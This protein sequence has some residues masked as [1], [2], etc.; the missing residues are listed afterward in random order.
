MKQITFTE[1]E[2][3]KL[4]IIKEIVEWKLSQSDWASEL[5]ISTRQMR[6]LQRWYELMGNESVIHGLK[7]K[8]S[9]FPHIDTHK[10]I[11]IAKQDKFRDYKPTLLT[12]YVFEEY[13]I[14]TS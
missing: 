5:R 7:G 13:W 3:R 1:K 10:I 2:T 8:E 4:H 9:N 14:K 12:E 11:D 6:R